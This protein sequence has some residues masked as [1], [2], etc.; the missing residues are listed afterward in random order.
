MG[1]I[2]FKGDPE[3]LYHLNSPNGQNYL[4]MDP[5]SNKMAITEERSGAAESSDLVE[6][7]DSVALYVFKDWL[8][9][10]GMVSPIGFAG[11]DLLYSHVFFDKGVYYGLIMK[12]LSENDERIPEMV[13]Y[14]KNKSP[15]Q[16]GCLST[17]QKFMILSA[18]SNGSKGVE[19]LY[20]CI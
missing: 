9:I 12:L 5:H 11:D 6:Y 20:V 15:F 17:D 10:K 3:P 13:P 1:Q 14:F 16:S 19:D 8:G 4:V 7:S 18:E 2:S